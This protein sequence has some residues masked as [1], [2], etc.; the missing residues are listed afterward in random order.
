MI[1]SQLRQ[2]IRESIRELMKEQY[3]WSG[4]LGDPCCPVHARPGYLGYFALNHFDNQG[5]ACIG[6]C[7]EP[8]K[9]T[10][11]VI[12]MA[13][14]L[15]LDQPQK[16]LSKYWCCKWDLLVGSPVVLNP[17]EPWFKKMWGKKK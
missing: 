3:S 11:S 6:G 9:E 1:K 16:S 5:N 4:I 2:L 10:G 8:G 12:D 13:E 15:S 14:Q 7:G 17:D